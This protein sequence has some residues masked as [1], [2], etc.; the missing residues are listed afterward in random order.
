[1]EYS[2]IICGMYYLVPRRGVDRPPVSSA[3]VK[4]SVELYVY[5]PIWAF[6]A[7]SGWNL[8]AI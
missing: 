2:Q 1:M 3:E 8:F 7:S 4:E 5:S 6:M